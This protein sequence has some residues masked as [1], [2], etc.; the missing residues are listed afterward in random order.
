MQGATKHCYIQNIQALGLV[1]S[2]KTILIG[3]ANLDPRGMVGR[4]YK[5]DY[6]TC[7]TQNIKPLGFMLLLQIFSGVV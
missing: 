1:V 7:Y 6:L 3:V 4:I 2:E 5:G